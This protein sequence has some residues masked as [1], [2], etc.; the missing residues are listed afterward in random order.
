MPN[1]NRSLFELFQKQE[2]KLVKLATEMIQQSQPQNSITESKSREWNQVVS[3]FEQGINLP[4]ESNKSQRHYPKNISFGDLHV[5]R[6]PLSKDNIGAVGRVAATLAG[7]GAAALLAHQSGKMF[8]EI[9]STAEK[10]EILFDCRSRLKFIKE[11]FSPKNLDNYHEIEKFEKIIGTIDTMMAQGR[12][13]QHRNLGLVG[14]GGLGASLCVLGGVFA[15]PVA[16][17]SGLAFGAASLIGYAFKSGLNSEN[18]KQVAQ[19]NKLQKL[20]NDL[21]AARAND[22]IDAEFKEILSQK[23]VS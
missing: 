21:S 17:A 3:I 2:K 22:S 1:T 12:Q 23:K 11:N 15:A 13:E 16:I 10:K 9:T 18:T 7:L 8:R 4:A 6:S 19:A 5:H 14:A 20:V